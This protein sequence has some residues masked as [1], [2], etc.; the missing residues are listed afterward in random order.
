M[1]STT[2]PINTIKNLLYGN[3]FGNKATRYGNENESKALLEFEKK[4]NLKVNESGFHIDQQYPFLG[5]SPDGLIGD[6]ALIEIKC[7]LSIKEHTPTDGII[8]KKISF[9]ELINGEL[10]LKRNHNY[11]FQIQG[12]LAITDRQFGYFLIWSPHGILVEKI[13][14]DDLF[15]K[16]TM[17]PKLKI[18]YNNCL[19]PELLDPL[20]PKGIPIRDK[21]VTPSFI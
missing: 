21:V 18:F 6:Q 7:P 9:A 19:L 12:Q 15:W 20:H 14:R 4:F 8:S 10:H 11:Y 1:R 2:S 16:E 13:T 17:L 5:A 3:F